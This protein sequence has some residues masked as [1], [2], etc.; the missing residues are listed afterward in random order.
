MNAAVA[1]FFA[2][3]A[4]ALATLALAPLGLWFALLA[5]IPLLGLG[6]DFWIEEGASLKA[7][8][9]RGF[10]IGQAFGFAYLALSLGWI[11]NALLVDAARYGWLVP[12]AKIGLPF[13]LALF[14]GLAGALAALLWRAGVGRIFALALALALADYLR[15]F[16]LTGF[17]WN[18]LVQG[19]TGITPL[20]Q[21]L[22]LVGPN[23]LGLIAVLVFAAPLA[24]I[25]SK[26]RRG[27]VL[28]GAF[29]LALFGGMF[30]YGMARLQTPLD[31]SGQIVRIVQPNVA[32]ADK[33]QPENRID[34]TKKLLALT[35]PETDKPT[36]VVWPEVALPFYMQND[37]AVL[38][39]IGVHL[40]PSDVLVTGALRFDTVPGREP[41]VYNG[42]MVIDTNGLIAATYDK[43]HLVPFGEYVP[44]KSLLSKLGFEKIVEGPGGFSEGGG[45]E[46]LALPGVLPTISPLICYE[47]IFPNRVVASV[48]P[49]PDVLLNVTNDAW[50][51]NSAGPPQHLAQARMRAVEQGLPLVRSA[52]TGISALIDPY[53]RIVRSLP[54]NEAGA[55]EAALPRALE[56][57][58]YVQYGEWPFLVLSG[59]IFLGLFRRR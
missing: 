1:I 5:A 49:R 59:L 53:G 52:N 9:R 19:L 17:P 3:G 51:G 38:A 54:L 39:A 21:T 15:S 34:I 20:M 2:L 32:Q 42:L 57:T 24:F 28:Y 30:S 4:G 50:Y 37:P 16:V 8:L 47:V 29:S 11:A 33:W 45:P 27:T 25:G 14:Y 40:P 35:T 55:I 31:I 58:L 36:L 10:I 43:H 48:G 7:R 46:T 56:T 13:G 6:F 22:S 18:N 12:L 26:G 44:L 23:G 41:R